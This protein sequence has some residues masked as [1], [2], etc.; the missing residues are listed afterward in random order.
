MVNIWET[1]AVSR[2]VIEA[3]AN[4]AQSIATSSADE[5]LAVESD[6]ANQHTSTKQTKP[7]TSV[8]LTQPQFILRLLNKDNLEDI[9][10]TETM[11]LSS[12]LE[13]AISQAIAVVK[14]N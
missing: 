8:K 4:Y 7:L 14:S 12:N 3:I 5:Q 6:Q 11:Y 13:A 9:K 10:I 1:E 2:E